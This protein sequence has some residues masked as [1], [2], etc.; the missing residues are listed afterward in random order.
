MN[1]NCNLREFN[2][3]V[4]NAANLP[5]LKMYVAGWSK[6]CLKNGI[7]KNK[8]EARRTTKTKTKRKPS[9]YNQFIGTCMK[10]CG[11]STQPCSDRMKEC[12]VEWKQQ[13]K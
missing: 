4:E 11:N 12:A 9:A 2:Q 13:R 10:G 1:F 8:K 6:K 5:V 3:K 7:P